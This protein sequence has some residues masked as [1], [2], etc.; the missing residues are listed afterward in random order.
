VN[1]SLE[2]AMLQHAVNWC[3]VCVLCVTTEGVIRDDS[4]TSSDRHVI[5]PSRT[6]QLYAVAAAGS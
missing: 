4:V 5:K 2:H 6:E 3:E 1:V